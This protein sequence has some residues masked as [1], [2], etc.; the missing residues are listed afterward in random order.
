[1]QGLLQCDMGQGLSVAG[2][3]VDSIWRQPGSIYYHPDI[4]EVPGVISSAPTP[5]LESS[6]QPLAILNAL[7]LPETLKGS[8][9]VGD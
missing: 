6:E 4:H 5:T 3:P 7:P 1:M 9:Q 2:V 8:S